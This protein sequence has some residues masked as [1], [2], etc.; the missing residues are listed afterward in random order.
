MLGRYLASACV[1][2]FLLALSA[3]ASAAEKRIALVIGNSTYKSAPLANPASDAQLMAKTLSDMGFDVI[4]VLNAD[5]K[6]MKRAVRDFGAR[7]E[8]SGQDTVGLFYYAGHGIQVKGE[9]FLVPIGAPIAREADVSIES[10]SAGAILEQLSFAKNRLNIVI[11]DA[12]RNNPFKRSFRSASSGLARMDAPTGSM[13][14]YSTAPGRVASDGEGQNGTYTA[15]LVRAMRQPGLKVEDVF[16]LTRRQVIAET[17][18]AQVPW[19]SSSLVGD[20]YFSR[21]GA[22]PSLPAIVAAQPGGLAGDRN[23]MAAPRMTGGAE[24]SNAVAALSA[25]RRTERFRAGEEFRDC[26]TC[27]RMTVVPEGRFAMGS[28]AKETGRLAHEGPTRQVRV[29]RFAMGR[30]EVTR[31]QFAQFVRETGYNASGGCWYWAIIFVFDKNRSWKNPGY[32][33]TDDHPVTCVNW[34]DARAYTLWLSQKTGKKYRLPTEAE[35]EYAARA[36][37]KSSRFWGDDAKKACAHENVYDRAGARAYRF[38]WAS[39][40]CDDG[41]AASAPVGK[42][43]ANGFGLHDMLGNVPEWVADCWRDSYRNAPSDGSAFT[44][45]DCKQRGIRGGSWS[46]WPAFSR[47]A[48]RHF[49]EPTDRGNVTGFRVARDLN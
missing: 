5:Q 44:S 6:T 19:E 36:G 17:S 3:T 9:N 16:K 46:L 2:L 26:P 8:R 47:S 37:T 11:L 35:W 13:V 22:A 10:V 49:D 21:A 14:A 29:P 33:Q 18:E 39:H 25:P 32:T 4:K 31:G 34:D 27:P 48:H 38:P 30:H 41:Y 23:S 15:A 1:V 45:S 43:R 7:I 40:D 42:F 20:F 28:G 24:P 12:C